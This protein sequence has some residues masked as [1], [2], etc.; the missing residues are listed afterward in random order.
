MHAGCCAVERDGCL[1]ALHAEVTAATQNDDGEKEA[2][3]LSRELLTV[4]DRRQAEEDHI[5]A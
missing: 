1:T 2:P 3:E 4:P 5:R